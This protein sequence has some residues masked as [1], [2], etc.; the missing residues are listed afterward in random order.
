MSLHRMEV[1]QDSDLLQDGPSGDR[2]PWESRFSPHVQTD[3]GAH[4]SSYKMG[5][6]YF[7]GVKWLGCNVDPLPHLEHEVKER[8]ELTSTHPLGLRG[9]L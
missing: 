9:L 7:P 2:I 6:E 8:V 3:P 5:T 4:P 1:G